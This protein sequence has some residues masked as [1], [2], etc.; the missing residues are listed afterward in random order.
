MA[1]RPTSATFF[2]CAWC[3]AT[4]SALPTIGASTAAV[5][6]DTI[7]DTNTDC[8]D[9]AETF[10]AEIAG[11]VAALSKDKR[12]RSRL[13]EEEYCRGWPR[14]PWQVQVCKL[15]DLFDNLMD[16][17]TARP[18]SVRRRWKTP[19]VTWTRCGRS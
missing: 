14:S 8:D 11:W 3:C 7:E 18:P 16:S 13:R 5:L 10:G 6:H 19:A 2:A 17:T 4:S 1:K 15:A 12:P 9:L